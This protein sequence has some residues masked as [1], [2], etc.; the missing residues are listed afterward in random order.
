MRSFQSQRKWR[1]LSTGGKN[2]DSDA[3]FGVR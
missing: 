3:V 1:L 2:L